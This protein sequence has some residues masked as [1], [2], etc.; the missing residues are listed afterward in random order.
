MARIARVV[1]EVSL[2]RAFDYEIPEEL[3]GQV[4]LGAKVRVPFKSR[5]LVGYVVEFPK[6][7]FAG[8]LKPILEVLGPRA[9]LP[10]I[11]IE[12]AQWMAQYYCAPLTVALLSV[13]PKAVRRADAAFKQRP[14]VEPLTATLPEEVALAMKKARVQMAAWE[15]LQQNGP[16]WLADLSEVAGTA[17]WRGLAERNLVSIKARTQ[18]RDPFL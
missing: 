4:T 3:D 11:L 10:P 6:E 17:A 7:P 12:L 1:P 16:G 2:D 5:D 15:Y 13:L 14:W 18:D 9:F 8:K